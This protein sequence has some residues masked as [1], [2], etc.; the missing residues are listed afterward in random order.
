MHEYISKYSVFKP[1]LA[2][3][4]FSRTSL[5]QYDLIENHLKKEFAADVENFDLLQP[6]IPRDCLD[7]KFYY[8]FLANAVICGRLEHEI[9]VM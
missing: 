1:L 5:E 2:K 4:I 7:F 9:I 6:T 3:M 8:D